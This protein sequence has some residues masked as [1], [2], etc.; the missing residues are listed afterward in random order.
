V[1]FL[2]IYDELCQLIPLT[3]QM[4]EGIVLKAET[5]CFELWQ[6]ENGLITQKKMK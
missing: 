3:K 2:I 5:D 4:L 6:D 1:F